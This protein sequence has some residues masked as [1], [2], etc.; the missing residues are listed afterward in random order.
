MQSRF[1][2][3]LRGFSL[4][5]MLVVIAIIGVLSLISVPAFM[6]FKN[7]N[8]FRANLRNFTHDLRAAR[9]YAITHAVRVRVELD[10]GTPTSQNYVFFSSNDNGATWTDLQMP[11]SHG[12]L[13][14][15]TGNI[16][17]LEGLV[18][19]NSST[20]LPDIGVNSK[21]DIIYHP[22][23]AMETT[24]GAA[25]GEVVMRC[26]WKQVAHD[27]YTIELSTSGQL[28]STGDHS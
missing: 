28:K 21:P 8:T 24:A 9:Q 13:P 27:R 20:A 16:K 11:G 15:T 2:H 5:E 18:W 17:N 14:G 25:R 7:A 22:N 23:G 4:I 10:S 19:F 26:E 12:A 1:K 6:N 3:S